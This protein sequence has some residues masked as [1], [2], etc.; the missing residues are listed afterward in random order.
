MAPKE[1]TET[2]VALV[3]CCA[4]AMGG[5]GAFTLTVISEV[6]DFNIITW[7]SHLRG[8]NES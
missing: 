2:H 6:P 7:E 8:R 1:P 4:Q 5:H 3:L